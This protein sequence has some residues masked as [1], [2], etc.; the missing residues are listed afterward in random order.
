[1]AETIITAAEVVAQ[2]GEHYLDA[3]QNEGD[4]H[5]RLRAGFE[6]QNAFQI[7]NTEDT[8][9]RAANTEFQ[10]ALQSFQR[11]YTPKGGVTFKPAEIKLFNV[12]V[13]QAFYPDDLKNS[14][15]GFLTSNDLD[16]T[17][18]PFVKWFVEM[19]IIPQILED[20]EL[21]AI[22][23]GVYKAP[24]PGTANNAVDVMNGIRKIINAYITA[25][26]TTPIVTGAF[27]ITDPKS[28]TTKMEGLVKAVPKLYSAKG[29]S[30]N[31]SKTLQLAYLEG[32]DL[33]YNS[34]YAQDPSNN[35]VKYFPGVNVNGYLSHEGSDKVWGTPALN[36][37]L[38]LKGGSN[39]SIVEMEKVDRM[40]KVYT[41]FW[42]GLDFIDP[43]LIF[44]NDQDLD[45]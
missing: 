9:L 27:D 45:A 11:A 19:Y 18:W 14:W 31:T 30:L 38:A 39:K 25:G 3:G 34:N 26:E 32:R 12:K 28:V 7:V 29:F 6:T 4:I 23:N 41:D 17:T 16:R 15:L 42:I 43:G 8:I 40:V 1:M 21:R 44:T 13:D 22:F 35:S 24:T 5:S 33:K 36:G 20:L 37:V 10:E 2:F